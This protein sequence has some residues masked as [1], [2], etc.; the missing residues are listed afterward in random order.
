MPLIIA[1]DLNVQQ[2]EC[3][4]E[5]LKR[6]KRAIGWTIADIIGIPADICSHKIKLM[7]DHKPSIELQRRLNTPMQEVVKKEIIVVRFQSHIPY[8]R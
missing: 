6:L 1:L 8:S 7:P 2:V 5:L 4:V 3:L